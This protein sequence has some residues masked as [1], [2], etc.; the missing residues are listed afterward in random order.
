MK[1]EHATVHIF[2]E[3][4]KNDQKKIEFETNEVTGRQIKEKAGVSLDCDLAR[5]ERGRLVS[6]SNDE[7]IKIQN[8]EHFVVVSCG[9]VS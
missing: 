7:K 9:T 2:V 6:V 5:K 4:T 1:T 3:I 8:G